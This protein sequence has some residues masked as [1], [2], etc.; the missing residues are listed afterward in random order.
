MARKKKKKKNKVI[1]DTAKGGPRRISSIL[2]G[3]LVA[4]RRPR[5]EAVMS[6]SGDAGGLF[7]IKE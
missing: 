2:V 7:P 3:R 5:V 1:K 4:D 6:D